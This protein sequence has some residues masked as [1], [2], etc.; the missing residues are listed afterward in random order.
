MKSFLEKRIVGFWNRLVRKQ[1][2]QVAGGLLV[3]DR[4]VDESVTASVVAIPQSRRAMH[5]V[6]LGRTGTGKSTLIR[7][8]CEQ[9][10]RRG[11]GF[12][13]GVELVRDRRTKAPF[14]AGRALSFDVGAR[15]FA[16]GLICY[17]CSGNVDGT[18]GDTII[19][20]PPYNAS[21][22]ELQ[23]I[24][25]KLARGGANFLFNSGRKLVQ[26]HCSFKIAH[27]FVSIGCR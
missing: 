10:I 6:I 3:G 17:P 20:A 9:D 19:I 23:D 13:I 15:A 12:F 18:A 21:D 2:S 4:V 1:R 24:V 16:D 27:G 7:S 22:G 14:P 26:R 25:T 8:F 5:L 11:R